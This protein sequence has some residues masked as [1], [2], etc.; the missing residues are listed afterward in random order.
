MTIGPLDAVISR[1][2][3]PHVPVGGV[4]ALLNGYIDLPELTGDLD[5]YL[6]ASTLEPDAGVLGALVLALQ[7]AGLS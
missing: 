4:R 5:R 3:D 2:R 6:V 7:A 1:D